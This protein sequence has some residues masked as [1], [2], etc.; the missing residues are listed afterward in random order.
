MAVS[1]PEAARL[2][3]DLSNARSTGP[4]GM[5]FAPNTAVGQRSYRGATRDSGG[6]MN[7]ILAAIPNPKKRLFAGKN[8]KRVDDF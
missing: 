7:G 1:N 5:A 8:Y 6:T 3:N 4:T 2:Q